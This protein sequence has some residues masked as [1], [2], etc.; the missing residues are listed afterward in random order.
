FR[1][2]TPAHRIIGKRDI[3]RLTLPL[4]FVFLLLA[5]FSTVIAQQGK[6]A[7]PM[8]RI[9]LRGRA[10]CLDEN[11]KPL[12]SHH[13]CNHSSA[14]FGFVTAEGKLYTFLPEDALTAMFTDRR[15]RERELQIGALLRAN[16]QLELVK[17]Q[18]VK[19]GKLYDLYFFCEVCNITAYGP[20]PCSCCYEEL[21]FKEIPASASSH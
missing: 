10:V 4:V 9:T 7:N 21:E 3:M 15:V 5:P 16:D 12:N 18:S 14:R 11:D 20:G 1:P 17:L 8:R 6:N 2:Q 19:D 13:D